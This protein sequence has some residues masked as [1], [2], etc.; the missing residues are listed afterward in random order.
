MKALRQRR[1][2]GAC[3][4]YKREQYSSVFGG[5]QSAYSIFL[6]GAMFGSR[7]II[8]LAAISGLV[9]VGIGAMG[10]HS[11]PR[12]LQESGLSESDI[13]KKIG[14]CEIAVK[15]QMYHTLAIL[16]IGLC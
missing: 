6:G 10:S 2:T 15:Y 1:R 12:R 13:Q 11:L 5:C 8:F 9:C 7:W 4:K 3:C 14:Q 16:A